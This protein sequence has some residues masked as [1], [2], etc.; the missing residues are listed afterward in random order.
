MTVAELA[1]GKGTDGVSTCSMVG[2]RMQQAISTEGFISAIYGAP[3]HW[4][5]SGTLIESSTTPI[6]RSPVPRNT[7]PSLVDHR[8]MCATS[9]TGS[10]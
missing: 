5:V 1:K 6:S 10:P 7:C 3:A 9:L 2:A 8:T 4:R